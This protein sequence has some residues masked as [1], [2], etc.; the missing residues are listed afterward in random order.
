MRARTSSGVYHTDEPAP[1]QRGFVVRL[2]P[3]IPPLLVLRD[4]EYDE[5]EYDPKPLYPPNLLAE[6]LLH[7]GHLAAAAAD[8]WPFTGAVHLAML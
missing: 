7:A 3:V 5:D 6:P 4:G 2:D 8:L 1:D